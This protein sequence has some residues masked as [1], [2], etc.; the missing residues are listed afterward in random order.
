MVIG[1][2]QVRL[3]VYESRSLKD[4]RRVIQSLKSRIRQQFNVSVAETGD[5]NS[6]QA[7]EVTAALVSNDSRFVQSG[8]QSVLNFIERQHTATLVDYSIDLI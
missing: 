2:L 5:L 3:A 7:A 4:K 8:L 6:R 1:V